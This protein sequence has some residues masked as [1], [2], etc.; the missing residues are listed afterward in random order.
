MSHQLLAAGT[1]GLSR[2]QMI[3]MIQNLKSDIG[4]EVRLLVSEIHAGSDLGVVISE[5]FVPIDAEGWD[6]SRGGVSMIQFGDGVM[7]RAERWDDTDLGAALARFDEI[8][9]EAGLP[10]SER[11]SDPAKA[12]AAG[13][14]PVAT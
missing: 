1:D 13:S 4:D 6:I 11:F 7:L 10:P 12:L 14:P 8:H 2:D 9:V 5:D 3:R